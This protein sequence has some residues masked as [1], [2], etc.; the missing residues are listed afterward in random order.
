MYKS[1][2]FINV[3]EAIKVVSLNLKQLLYLFQNKKQNYNNKGYKISSY[4]RINEKIIKDN[5]DDILRLMV[6]IK[7][8]ET[9]ASQIFKRLSFYANKHSLYK[10]LKEFGRITKT[11]FL[12]TYFDDVTLRQ[13]IQK[14]LNKVELANKFSGV[15]FFANNKE[16][17][18]G[19]KEDQEIATNCKRLI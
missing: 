12:L 11:G 4:K 2:L 10:A 7:L 15:V 9:T 14:Q 5:W 1:L 13:M 6:T 19:S 18:Q 17:M 16:F 8:K 3:A